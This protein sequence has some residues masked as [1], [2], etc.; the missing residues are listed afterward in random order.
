MNFNRRDFLK[1]SLASLG[2]FALPGG[3]FAAPAGWKPKKKPDLV[4]GVLS[5]THLMVNRRNGKSLYGTMSLDYIRNAFRYFKENN[6]D[7]FVHLGDASHRGDSREWEFHKEVFEEVFGPNGPPRIVVVGNHELFTVDKQWFP[8]DWQTRMIGADLPRHYERIWGEPYSEVLHK[9][10]KGFHFFGRHWQTPEMKLAESVNEKAAECSLAGA[11][12]FFLLSHARNHFQC[13]AAMKAF[14][15]AIAFFG[16]WH[17]SNADWKTIYHSDKLFPE[18]C[19][20]ACR[21]DGQNTLDANG[22]TLKE[23]DESDRHNWHDN[24]VKSRQAMVMNVYDDMVVFERHEVG[25]GGKLGADWVMPLD[26]GTGNGE[27]GTGRKVHPFTRGELLKVIGNPEFP[28]RAKLDVKLLSPQGDLEAR[29]SGGRSK[30]S[31]SLQNSKTPSSESKVLRIT[32]PL[33]DGNPD[34]RVFAYDVVVLGDDVKARFFKSV[35]Y[36]GCNLGVGHEPGKG[37]TIVDIPQSQLPAGKKIT[38]AVRP[39]S[40]LGTKGK[41]I[42]TAVRA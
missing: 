2:F 17:Q 11:K 4:F 32:I 36:E 8:N 33:A 9:E 21:N 39:V 27:R 3:V 40:S 37:V 34:S 25:Q 22:N 13:R 38:I 31:P 41:T 29:S 24:K 6:I 28:P 19:C 30:K 20:G 7:A 5:D 42:G 1:G 10:V 12:P 23:P 16:H 14:P 15:N 18:I 26:W 35:Y